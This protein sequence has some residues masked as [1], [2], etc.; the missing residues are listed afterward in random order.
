MPHDPI[1]RRVKEA[2]IEQKF[3]EAMAKEKARSVA[4]KWKEET[5]DRKEER[6]REELKVGVASALICLCTGAVQGYLKASV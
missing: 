3:R 1:P 2:E 6:I 5:E 4:G